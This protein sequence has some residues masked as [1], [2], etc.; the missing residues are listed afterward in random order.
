MWSHLHSRLFLHRWKS[1]AVSER[2]FSAHTAHV[3]SQ[4]CTMKA[5]VLWNIH[6]QH[7]V[8]WSSGQQT[9]VFS[10]LSSG[11]PHTSNT[12]KHTSGNLVTEQHRL[13]ARGLATHLWW[14]REWW[15]RSQSGTWPRALPHSP[16]SACH[17]LRHPPPRPPSQKYWGWEFT[18]AIR[19]MR[20]STHAAHTMQFHLLTCPLCVA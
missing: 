12:D 8:M 20:F 6:S 10:W 15:S 9:A 2:S 7:V 17:N 18:A 5:C 16:D 4:T 13:A 11:P 1:F 3:R 14:V 19:L